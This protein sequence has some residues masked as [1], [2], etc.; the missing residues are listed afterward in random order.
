VLNSA[1]FGA[2]TLAPGLIVT[3]FGRNLGP[4]ELAVA[5]PRA[6]AYPTDLAG[7]RVLF[8]D[9]A[10][11]VIYTSSG[12]ISTVV[13]FNVVP[14]TNA[15]VVVEY[16][17]IRSPPVS[18]FVER[19]APG[20]FTRDSSGAGIAAVL[21]VDPVTGGVSLNSPQNPAQRGGVIVAFIT[22]AGRTDPPSLDGAVATDT[23]G[24]ALSVA[25]GLEFWAVDDAY[26]TDSPPCASSQWCQPV[27]VLYAGPAPGLI[28]GVTQVNLRLP[29]TTRASGTHQLGVSAGGIWSQRNVTISV[30]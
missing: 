1:S 28:A 27:E 25:A 3:I 6:G 20:M 14:G 8:N 23:G 24:L 13:P 29:D 15:K 12:Q 21:N 9:V 2:T 11:P 10:A 16:Q 30:R 7:T 17:G 4:G 5:S 22:G 18:I 26:S 19:S